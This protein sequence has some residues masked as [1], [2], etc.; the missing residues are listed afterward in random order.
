MVMKNKIIINANSFK[1]IELYEEAAKLKYTTKQFIER[2]YSGI[3]INIDQYGWRQW[4]FSNNLM[5]FEFW[6]KWT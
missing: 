5:Y 6:I 3:E 2:K 4:E 1:W